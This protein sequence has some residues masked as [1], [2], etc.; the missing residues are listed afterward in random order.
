MAQDI[1]LLKL[2][3]QGIV[4]G[5]VYSWI[6][7]WVSLGK[8]QKPEDVLASSIPY[9]IRPTGGKA[10]LHGHDVTV[11]LAVPLAAIHCSSRDVKKAYR[12]V[13]RPLIEALNGCGMEAS[14]AEDTEH[15]H[16]GDRTADCF[17]FNSANDIVDIY[18]GKKVCGCA[19]LMTQSA[20]LIQASIPI[21]QPL[22]NPKF[23]IRGASDYAAP[24]W[25]LSGLA[26]HLDEVLRYNFSNVS[27][28]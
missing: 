20:L 13:C 26:V 6:G 15:L 14:L 9:V 3:D 5:R 23:A 1:K 12:S 17:A 28:G 10:V 8:F 4:A 25:D 27:A 2:A 21:G 16:R 7:P 24:Q 22:I 11:G 19:L 18:T